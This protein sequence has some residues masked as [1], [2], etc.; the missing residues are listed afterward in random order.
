MHNPFSKRT[1]ASASDYLQRKKN[2]VK[3]NFLKNHPYRTHEYNLQPA[4]PFIPPNVYPSESHFVTYDLKD[5]HLTPNTKYDTRKCHKCNTDLV[6]MTE[7]PK[8]W[9]CD[10]WN[11]PISH[12]Q[13]AGNGEKL[14]QAYTAYCC[15]NTDKCNWIVCEK[16]FLH[17]KDDEE[18]EDPHQPIDYEKLIQDENKQNIEHRIECARKNAPIVTCI[19]SYKEYLDLTKGFMLTEPFCENRYPDTCENDDNGKLVQNIC[20]AKYSVLDMGK[21]CLYNLF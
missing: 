19:K 7:S 12:C 1:T 21:S 16:C 14:N 4:I 11:P 10:G 15:P 2:I 17:V 9:V 18:E 6:L 20:E 5:N 8:E 13:S 3:I